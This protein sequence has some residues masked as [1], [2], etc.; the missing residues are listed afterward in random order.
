MSLEANAQSI[1]AAHQTFHPRFGWLKKGFDAVE[2]DPTVFSREDAP[3]VLGVG[4][5]M[6]EAIRFWSQAFKVI[7]PQ[8]KVGKGRSSESILISKTQQACG[9]C[10]GCC[11]HRCLR[12]LSGGWR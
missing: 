9:F 4:K 12:C 11:A 6:V 10:I 5:N 3:L 1:F 8:K 7:A 2:K